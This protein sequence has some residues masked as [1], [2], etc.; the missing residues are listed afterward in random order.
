MLWV[1]NV[2]GS[3]FRV[4]N[5]LIPRQT[6]VRS[7]SGICAVVE[8]SELRR[9]GMELYKE[10]LQLVAQ[11]HSHPTNAYHSETD[12]EFAIVTT[13]GGLSLVVPDF[14]VG[15]FDLNEY[16]AY[17]LTESGSWEELNRREVARLIEVVDD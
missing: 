3:S 5:L 1:G 9:I 17:R 16:A 12:D 7:D 15:P 2:D 4:T 14:A 6:A 11:V 13:M 10:K 8:G